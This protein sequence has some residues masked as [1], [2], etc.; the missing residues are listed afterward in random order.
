MHVLVVLGEKLPATLSSMSSILKHR[1]DK[2]LE[3]YTPD[4]VILVCGG[5]VQKRH[6][7]TEAYVMKRYLKQFLPD[8]A[9]VWMEA[10]SQTTVENAKYAYRMLRA[11]GKHVTG[12][13]LITSEFH[14]KR[15]SKIFDHYNRDGYLI[16]CKASSNGVDGTPLERRRT[17]ERTYFSEFLRET[18]FP[19]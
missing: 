15:A 14:M 7:H 12:V 17:K 5:R 1:L 2:A 4:T 19:G 10:K 16:A 18:A 11:S 6:P 13:S 3:L 9:V 8:H